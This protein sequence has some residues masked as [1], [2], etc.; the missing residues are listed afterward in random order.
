MGRIGVNESAQSFGWQFSPRK[1]ICQTALKELRSRLTEG[2]LGRLI[3]SIDF[4]MRYLAA[5]FQRLPEIS[6]SPA[7]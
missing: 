3:S 4:G 5:H 1:N 7:A 2:G 6:A